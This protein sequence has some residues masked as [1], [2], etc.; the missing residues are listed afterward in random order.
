LRLGSII[1]V[2]KRGDNYVSH[3][4]VDGMGRIHG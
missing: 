4:K 3:F 2:K 1:T